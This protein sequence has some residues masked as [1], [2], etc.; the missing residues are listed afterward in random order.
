MRKRRLRAFR[1]SGEHLHDRCLPSGYTPSQVATAYGLGAISFRPILGAAVVGDGT[2]QTIAIVDENHDPNL[3]ASL[4]AFDTQY[5]LPR[6]TLNVINQAGNQTDLGWAVEETLDVEWAH[7]IAPGAG[8]AVVESSPGTTAD[9]EFNNILAAVRTASQIPG[10]SVVSMSWGYDEFPGETS[11]DSTFTTTG[12]TFIAASGDA[13]TTSWPATSANVLAV[14][15]TSLRL[16]AGGG[17]GSETGWSMAGGGLSTIVTEP[18]YQD[19]VQSTGN[20]STPDVAFDADPDTGVSIYV[21]PPDNTAGQGRW[22]VVGGTSLS[23][24]SWAGIM[25]IVN[26]GRAVAGLPAL[27]GSTQTVPGLYALSA[28]AFN[29]VP[30]A[31]GG[32]GPN[33]SINTPGYN[34]QAGRGSPA[35]AALID[36]LVHNATTTPTPTPSPPSAPS[37]PPVHLP[38]PRP[39]PIPIPSPTPPPPPVM[40]PSPAP[41]PTPAPSPTPPP[42][43]PPQPPPGPA[44]RQKHH[45][46]TPKSTSTH[47]HPPSRHRSV[48]QTTGPGKKA[49]PGSARPAPGP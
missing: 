38:T 19:A 10:V 29:K 30:V 40:G 47:H 14:G 18:S 42:A 44:P 39:I 4:D 13:G 35:G 43:T 45:V 33:T 7:A 12:V 16:A 21:I 1:P 17:Y 41:L 48:A 31:S 27:T 28:S 37:P 36:A 2:G 6:V 20:R 8:I 23:A 15:G 5:N 22:D 9:Q 11:Y 49:H 34:T 25:A 32:S 24:P 3:Q 26:Q 46:R